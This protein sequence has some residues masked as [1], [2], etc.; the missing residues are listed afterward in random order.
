MCVVLNNFY[1]GHL[2][3][4][5]NRVQKKCLVD[6]ELILQYA[7]YAIYNNKYCYRDNEVQ[8][9]HPFSNNYNKAR[10]TE[11]SQIM[12]K[13]FVMFLEQVMGYDPNKYSEIVIKIGKLF[14]E[15]TSLTFEDFYGNQEVEN[16]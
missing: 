16:A 2:L 5:K 12:I 6:G 10:A 3:I 1:S 15:P 4:A 9:I 8:I 11:E 14:R 7:A 13:G